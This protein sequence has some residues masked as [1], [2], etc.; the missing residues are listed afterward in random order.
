MSKKDARDIQINI[1]SV[2]ISPK[3][4]FENEKFDSLEISDAQVGNFGKSDEN[5]NDITNIEDTGSINDKDNK[6]GSNKGN[7]VEGP[8][9]EDN[10]KEQEGQ[11]P[12]KYLTLDETVWE[13]IVNT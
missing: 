4:N 8:N 5:P 12:N 13:T 11:N 2:D 7:R 3:V 1:E 6:N 9:P 10:I